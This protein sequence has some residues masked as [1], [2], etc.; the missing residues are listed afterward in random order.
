MRTILWATVS[1]QGG[2]SFLP[3]FDLTHHPTTTLSPCRATFHPCFPPLFIIAS[4]SNVVQ[5]END[6][7]TRANSHISVFRT[8]K[9]SKGKREERERESKKRKKNPIQLNF[10]RVRRRPFFFLFF[11]FSLLLRES[12]VEGHFSVSFV[13]IQSTRRD[14]YSSIEPSRF[15]P[16][17]R[18]FARSFVPT[19]SPTLFFFFYFFKFFLERW[20]ERERELFHQGTR[21]R[22]KRG[23]K[24]GESFS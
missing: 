10:H 19:S 5:R 13:G 8:G 11:S 18:S 17:I 7:V 20:R 1:F 4:P 24:N 3:W 14:F 6:R 16:S 2:Q 15:F 22:W 21:R 12:W 9:Q 23:K